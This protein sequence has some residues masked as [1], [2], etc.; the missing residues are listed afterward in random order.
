M[1]QGASQECERMEMEVEGGDNKNGARKSRG[2]GQLVRTDLWAS[3]T[4]LKF[5][6]REGYEKHFPLKA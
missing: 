2:A 4:L 3:L 6:N 5:G 1:H